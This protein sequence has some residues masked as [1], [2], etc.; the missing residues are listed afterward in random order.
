M[1]H[2]SGGGGGSFGGGGGSFDSGSGSGGSSYHTSEN[3]FPGADRYVYYENGQPRYIYSNSD[4]AK[5]ASKWRFLILLAYIPFFAFLFPLFSGVYNRPVRLDTGYETSIVIEDNANV[6]GERDELDRTM[7]DFFDRTGISPALVTVNNEDWEG[8]IYG[9][10]EEFA[11]DCYLD[12]FGDEDHWLIVYSEPESP[13]D[14]DKYYWEGMQGDNTDDLLSKDCRDIFN[15]NLNKHLAEGDR[16]DV[17]GSV[18]L[19]FDS[20]ESRIMKPYFNVR[21]AVPAVLVLLFLLLHAFIMIKSLLKMKK[22]K[23]AVRVGLNARELKCSSCGGSYVKGAFSSCPHCGAP[24]G[25]EEET[26]IITNNSPRIE[27]TDPFGSDPYS[28]KVR[29]EDIDDS[30]LP[31]SQRIKGIFKS[32]GEEE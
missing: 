26:E 24:I 12:H 27:N 16:P 15:H 31:L 19:A 4:P 14:G 32:P 5:G 2:S 11:Y 6:L 10:L 21:K 30:E 23:G 29:A 17:A 18:V 1:P 3:Y 28:G 25:A 20:I 7:K 9:S 22:Y 13:E 8:G